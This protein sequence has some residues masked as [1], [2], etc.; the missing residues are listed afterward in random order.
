MTEEPD[1]VFLLKWNQA[2]HG[3]ILWFWM[4]SHLI[5]CDILQR[6]CQE[7]IQMMKN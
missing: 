6:V 7:M 4:S 2:G 1:K 5:K 3:I